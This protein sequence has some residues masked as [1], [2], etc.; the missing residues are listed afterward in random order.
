MI[1]LH[2][3]T[4]SE[5][6][7]LARE[8]AR[9][10]EAPRHL[11]RSAVGLWASRPAEAGLLAAARQLRRQL[12]AVL[13]FDSSATPGLALGMR[14]GAGAVRHLVFQSPAFDVDL[15]VAAR[16]GGF[17]LQGQLLGSDGPGQLRLAPLDRGD[18]ELFVELDDLAEFR[19]P[20]LAPGRYRLSLHTAD[21][22]IVLP[23]IAIG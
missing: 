12:V 18:E 7:Q 10:P 15:R 23:E 21:D 1:P 14:G 22:D 2:Q 9:L 17:E 3:R 6:E 19:L 11:V 4:D 20:G 5:F 8:A 13:G 16:A